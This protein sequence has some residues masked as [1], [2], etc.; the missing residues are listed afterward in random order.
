MLDSEY[1]EVLE[2]MEQ[3]RR[4][5]ALNLLCTFT[6]S[7][8]YTEDLQNRSIVNTVAKDPSPV[9]TRQ[10]VM[11][12]DTGFDLTH[13]VFKDKVVG[14]YTL[15]CRDVIKQLTLFFL[16]IGDQRRKIDTNQ[17]GYL[18]KIRDLEIEAK[19]GS[20]IILDNACE[21]IANIKSSSSS[22]HRQLRADRDLWN[23]T[24]RTK[25]DY[26]S[27]YEDITT[28][29]PNFSDGEIWR[30]I[31]D[32]G[33]G[34]STAGTIA[35]HNDQIALVLLEDQLLGD[36]T[37][38]LL[39]N[40]D[41]EENEPAPQ[42]DVITCSTQEEIDNET[43]IY[44]NPVFLKRFIE[45]PIPQFEKDLADLMQKHKVRLANYSFGS[46][47]TEKKEEVGEGCP[48]INF[49]ENSAALGAANRA[50][51]AFVEKTLYPSGTPFL[52]VVSA[53]NQS[54][55][56]NDLA[57][58]NDCRDPMGAI[59]GVG[60]IDFRAGA[61][62]TRSEFTNQ[63]ACVDGY[64][65]GS[66]IIAPSNDQFYNILFG[67]S[68]SAPIVTRFLALNAPKD[69]SP[70]EIKKF[71]LAAVDSKTKNLPDT[72]HEMKVVYDNKNIDFNGAPIKASLSLNTLTPTAKP[73]TSDLIDFRD[74]HLLRKLLKR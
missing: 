51:S 18:E 14:A 21:L 9:D 7:C 5:F 66:R 23:Q 74:L 31:G 12:R 37:A 69:A 47:A 52:V 65:Y 8:F 40:L 30:A 44:K 73:K 64:A 17:A 57:D 56:I 36:S 43:A 19:M 11:V 6:T 45:R 38:G 72:A 29:N 27:L 10:V 16:D 25:K 15:D 71:F 50:R 32:R 63:G 67:T 3:L 55:T 28:A 61:T 35:L 60:S 24:I 41:L 4:I 34:T 13:E 53:G 2:F 70:M 39:R 62:P 46:P 20:V 33:H 54:A 42:E 49:R 1:V 48:T 58:K 68:F 22:L 26:L 59:V